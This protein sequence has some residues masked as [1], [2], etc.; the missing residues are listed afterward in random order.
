MRVSTDV[1]RID[2]VLRA[3]RDAVEHGRAL[4]AG[5]ARAGFALGV[6]AF[7]FFH[8]ALIGERHHRRELRVMLHESGEGDL[9]EFLA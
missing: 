6:R 9:R 7:R 4:R 3:V 5:F 8:A 1:R 2:D